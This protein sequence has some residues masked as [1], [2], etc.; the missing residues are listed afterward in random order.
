MKRF[1]S[2][3]F[4]ISIIYSLSSVIVRADFDQA[5]QDYLYQSDQYRLNLTN[6]LTAKNRYLTYQTLTSETE[7][8]TATK[9]FLE[10]R[11]QVLMTYLQMLI[12]KN[13][14]ENLKK[15]LSLFVKNVKR[16]Y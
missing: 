16:A 15:F 8:L 2:I 12:E 4:L 6:F 7:A 3:V 9:S 13:P 1:L 5:Y 11:D 14:S 10:A